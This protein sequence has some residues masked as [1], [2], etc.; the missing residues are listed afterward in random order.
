MPA[1]GDLSF[2]LFDDTPPE[3]VGVHTVEPSVLN[4]SP[5]TYMILKKMLVNKE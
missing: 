2:D 5:G 3:V 4:E 1:A